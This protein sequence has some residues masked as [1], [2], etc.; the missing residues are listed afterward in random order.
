MGNDM[1]NRGYNHILLLLLCI[2]T[3]ILFACIDG[4]NPYKDY[5][6][7]K[8]IIA[9]DSPLQN[10]DT[11]EVD[12]KKELKLAVHLFEYI[13]SFS[14]HISGSASWNDTTV[15]VFDGM[16]NPLSFG[17]TFTGAGVK[18]VD[19]ITYYKGGSSILTQ[20]ITIYSIIIGD[21]NGPLLSV[22]Y[23]NI[24]KDTVIAS[25]IPFTIDIKIRDT[26]SGLDTG[27]FR[28][29]DKPF[30][31]IVLDNQGVAHGYYTFTQSDF[32]TQ[33]V[34]VIVYA[35]D[36]FG[37]GSRDTFWIREGQTT[38][39][40]SVTIVREDPVGD[41]VISNVDSIS[42]E[43]RV[44]SISDPASFY[45]LR[46]YVNNFL[47][48][49]ASY[50]SLTS[51]DWILNCVLTDTLNTIL[52]V[53][54]PKDDNLLEHPLDSNAFVVRYQRA[55]AEMRSSIPGEKNKKIIDRT[56]DSLYTLRERKEIF[57]NG[58]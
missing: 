51:P 52:L 55:S 54:Y 38:F 35:E 14:M 27:T 39:D 53:I 10:G 34:I 11:V 58:K 50:T 26:E 24:S 48:N 18:T 6:Q 16:S 7:S 4:T 15:K 46:I 28:I 56:Y 42:I 17:I 33:P 12:E 41:T 49:I 23:N 22:V 45:S 13:D 5:S 8:V 31:T 57:T 47:L 30:E 21:H 25:T 32:N 44:D 43:G 40:S 20:T 1:N 3:A 2:S 9:D 36:I 19:I 37:N 29:N